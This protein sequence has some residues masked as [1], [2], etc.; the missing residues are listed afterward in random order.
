MAM[1]PLPPGQSWGNNISDLYYT[2]EIPEGSLDDVEKYEMLPGFV[3]A[4]TDHESPYL[5]IQKDM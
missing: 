5:I 2:I 3:S 4:I 1:L